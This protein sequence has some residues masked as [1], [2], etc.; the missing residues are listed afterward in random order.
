MDLPRIRELLSAAPRALVRDA[1][2]A[3]QERARAAPHLAPPD[4]SAWGD[5]VREEVETR[6]QPSLRPL[7]NATGVVLHTNLG[8]APLPLAA[9]DAITR[10]ASLGSNLEYDLAHGRRGARHTH[11]ASL[12][13]EL[14][15]AE[16]ALVMNNG[17][18]A[19]VLALNTVA[20]GRE[21]IIS[22]GELIEIGGSFR[23]PESMVKSGAVLREVGTTNRTHADDYR[24]ALSPATGAVVKVHRSNFEMQGFVAEATLRDL[25]PIAREAAVPLLFDFGSGLLIPLEKFGLEGE[26][27]AAD[28]IRDGATLAV[29]SG[30]K[31]LGGPQAGILVGTRDAIAACRTNPLA[32]AFRVDKLALAALEATLAMYRDPASAVREIPT[33]R[34]LTMPAERV[35]MRASILATSLQQAGI[36]CEVVSTEASVGGGAF[37]TARIPSFAVSPSGVADELARRLRAARVPVIG[38]VA[39]DRLLLDVRSVPD[40]F[41]EEL[42]SATITALRAR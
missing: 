23:V 14:T 27:V 40:L 15:G 21:A 2:R 28:A 37:P 26:P 29:M 10:V 42:A 36:A 20:D 39:D 25:V 30:D 41:D 8:R 3:V 17:A 4:E 24:R 32:R 33:L 31:L 11:C 16:D 1:I 6:R 13:C 5:A 18:A 38:R 7:F 12:L 9:V 22:R 34:M 19:L 35:R